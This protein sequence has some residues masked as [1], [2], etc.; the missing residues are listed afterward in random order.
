MAISRDPAHLKAHLCA[1]DALLRLGQPQEALRAYQEGQRISPSNP[2]AQV[3]FTLHLILEVSLTIPA[4]KGAFCR[5]RP[6]AA[7]TPVNIIPSGRQQACSGACSPAGE[8]A[9]VGGSFISPGYLQ[10]P[11]TPGAT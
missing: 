10:A 4:C 2:S 11:A 1:A 7:D 3:L 6:T 8:R 9:G 5:H